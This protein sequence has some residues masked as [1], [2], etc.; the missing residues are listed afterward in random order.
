M[1]LLSSWS[2]L[3]KYGCDCNTLYPF[4]GV[5]V[6]CL[7]LKQLEPRRSCGLTFINDEIKFQAL[8]SGILQGLQGSKPRMI[9]RKA[10]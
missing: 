9:H 3:L 6:L 1:L 8:S 4:K 2:I 7:A 5:I 10:R